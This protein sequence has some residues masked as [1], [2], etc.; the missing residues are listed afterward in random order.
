ML[1]IVFPHFSNLLFVF[2][3]LCALC[4]KLPLICALCFQF[5]FQLYPFFSPNDPLLLYIVPNI[6]FKFVP[7]CFHTSQICT[8]CFRIFLETIHVVVKFPQIMVFKC[9]QNVVHFV[10]RFMF[11]FLSTLLFSFVHFVSKFSFHLYICFSNECSFNVYIVFPNFPVSC[12]LYTEHLFLQIFLYLFFQCSQI[13]LKFVPSVCTSPFKSVHLVSKFSFKLYIVLPR[14]FSEF[15]HRVSKFP[16]ICTLCF[17]ISLYMC[18]CCFQTFLG[19][20]TC[21]VPNISLYMCTCCFQ[22]SL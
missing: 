13:H 6:C 19:I 5:S 20:Y 17:H 14:F 2:P 3:E 10:S 21:F 16:L 1:Y 22:T 18:T 11:I 12:A 4:S 15:V 9:P 8:C 7:H